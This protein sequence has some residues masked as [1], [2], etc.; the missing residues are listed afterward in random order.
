MGLAIIRSAIA[1]GASGLSGSSLYEFRRGVNPRNFCLRAYLGK[2]I[3]R[4]SD[5]VERG[6]NS[7]LIY[8]VVKNTPVA[9]FW[10]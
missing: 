9:S 6:Q 4:R 3:F 2:S 10:R 8:D 5:P 7:W 1:N